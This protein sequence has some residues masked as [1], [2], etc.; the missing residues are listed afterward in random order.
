MCLVILQSVTNYIV[1]RPLAYIVD[2]N[3]GYKTAYNVNSILNGRYIV[4]MNFLPDRTLIQGYIDTD[5]Y[6]VWIVMSV[7]GYLFVGGVSNGF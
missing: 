6:R 4:I 2:L 1:R 7:C 5:L 3:N